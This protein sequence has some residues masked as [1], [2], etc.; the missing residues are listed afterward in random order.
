MFH[1]A[2]MECTLQQDKTVYHTVLWYLMIMLHPHT[3]FM[4]RQCGAENMDGFCSA[5]SMKIKL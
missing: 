5:E 2:M 1:S 3:G 4:S